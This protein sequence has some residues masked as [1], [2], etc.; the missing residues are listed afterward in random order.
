M[1]VTSKHPEYDKNIV[2]W[3][4]VRDVINSDV[5]KYIKEIDPSDPKRT[6]R[7][8]DDACFT[9]FTSR[10]KNGLVGAVFCKDVQVMLPPSIEYLEDDATGNKMGI[11]KLSQEV[12]GEVLQSGRY[13]LLVDYPA[14]EDGLSA[15]EVSDMNLKARICKYKAENIINW[16][17]KL[18]NGVYKLSLVVLKECYSDIDVDGF[19]WIEVT[20]YRVLRLIDDVYVQQLYSEADELIHEYVPRM[21]DG[22]SWDHIPF[23]F[24]GAEDNDEAVDASP[25]YD[26]AE[27]NIGH[28]RNSA[29]YEESIHVTGQPTFIISTQMSS[30]EFKNANPNGIQIGARRGHN[31]GPSGTAMLLQASPNQLADV[32]M[33]RKEEQAVMLG[34][35]LVMQAGSNET[36]E[37]ARIKHS[38]EHSV[39]ATIVHNVND[40]M[41]RCIDWCI[42]FMSDS[43]DA[44]MEEVVFE[45][46]D[47]FFD[48]SLDPNMVMAQLQLYTN[49]IIAATDIRR[50]LRKTGTIP[51][52]RTDEDIENDVG[53]IN[54]FL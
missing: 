53:S 20:Q 48:I 40:A 26:L 31:L 44:D 52:D 29:D 42:A 13:G 16:Q 24:V 38:G 15:A 41:E 19:T 46:S 27:L 9:N 14:S 51:A 30:E 49:G 34:A 45:I 23:V 43:V 11:V 17:S 6:T 4:V 8:R 3:E 1:S 2:R 54:P 37:A 21:Y 22:S 28:L 32:A 35:R 18:T 10:T 36:A 50:T 25:L 47:Q 12:V 5:K 39:L 7:Y 33:K